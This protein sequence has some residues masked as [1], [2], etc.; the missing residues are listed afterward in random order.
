MNTVLIEDQSVMTNDKK[1]SQSM[2]DY[3]ILG[4]KILSMKFEKKPNEYQFTI[5]DLNNYVGA[6]RKLVIN[7]TYEFWVHDAALIKESK[8]FHQI[9]LTG[10]KKPTKEMIVTNNEIKLKRTFIDIPHPEYFFD[11]LTWIYSKDSKRLSLASDEPE[12]FLSLLSLGIYIE[13]SEFFFKTLLNS[14]EIKLDENLFDYKLWSRFSF[15]FDVLINLL[16]LMPKDNDFMKINAMIS[17]LKEDNSLRNNE[18]NDNIKD[19]EFEL[20][21]SKD[22]FNVKNFLT[23]NRFIHNISVKDLATLKNKFG[24]LVQ[25]L[26]TTFLIEKYVLKSSVKIT[27]RVCRKVS[28][29]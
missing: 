6:D 25:V 24:S 4:K 17:W 15:T 7:D 3:S 1:T 2:T 28:L 19:K 20:L 14:C 12:S 27:C 9:F 13:M 22:Y 16:S 26:D 8:Y 10:E 11:V 23:E 29:R 21:T 18:T 5:N